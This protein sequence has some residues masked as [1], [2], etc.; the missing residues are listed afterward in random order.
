MR[1]FREEDSS[2]Q[3]IA[4]HKPIHTTNKS[5]HCVYVTKTQ[6]PDKCPHVESTDTFGQVWLLQSTRLSYPTIMHHCLA[7]IK[8]LKDSHQEQLNL[9]N[10]VNIPPSSSPSSPPP[11]RSG[12]LLPPPKTRT[13]CSASSGTQR[14]RLA[15]ICLLYRTCMPPGSGGVQERL[16]PTPLTPATICL[17]Y[18]PLAG[19]YG[20]SG[21]K[22]PAT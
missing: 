1:L 19:G 12:T 21:P 8:E 15:A 16:W 11:S 2:E 13:D 3:F 5:Q 22:P 4:A 17:N 7:T 20:P 14:R 6:R 9:T 10:P 18:F